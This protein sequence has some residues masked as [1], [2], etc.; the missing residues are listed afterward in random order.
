MYSCQRTGYVHR[1]EAESATAT[2]DLQRTPNK[3][4]MIQKKKNA[5]KPK[6]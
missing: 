6:K 5:V 2:G 4:I 1:T 3:E